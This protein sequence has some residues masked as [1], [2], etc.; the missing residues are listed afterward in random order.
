MLVLLISLLLNQVALGCTWLTTEE[1]S[2][3]SSSETTEKEALV[4]PSVF[5]SLHARYMRVNSPGVMPRHKQTTQ[6]HRQ[7]TDAILS[8]ESHLFVMRC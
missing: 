3:T 4:Q 1:Q 7:L 2:S 5:R 8:C 6:R